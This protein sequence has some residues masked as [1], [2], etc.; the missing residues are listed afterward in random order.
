MWYLPLLL[1]LLRSERS[2]P[3]LSVQ[4][5]NP[6]SSLESSDVR[7]DEVLFPP[8]FLLYDLLPKR[9]RGLFPLS[10]L[11]PISHPVFSPLKRHV[12][13]K[14][15]RKPFSFCCQCPK[16]TSSSFFRKALSPPPAQ[17]SLAQLKRKR[18][19]AFTLLP[20]SLG[21]RLERN[22]RRKR[23]KKSEET[24]KCRNTPK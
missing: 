4:P 16:L 18:G 19:K 12:V 6:S 23:K 21:E 22:E 15:E 10:P 11:L 17:A 14:S 13:T 7:L 2:P 20:L 3:S 1:F 9:D 24:E 8:L 5:T